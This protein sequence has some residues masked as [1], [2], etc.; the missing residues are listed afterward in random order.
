MRRYVIPP[1]FQSLAVALVINRLD[2]G[3]SIYVGLL[4]SQIRQLQSVQNAASRLVFGLRR[5]EHITDVV[6][7]LHYLRV[8][9]RIA[10][11]VALLIFRAL[12]GQGRRTCRSG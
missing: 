6:V 10:F 12:H 8:Q 9:E 11:K 3:N 2:I 1:V 5:S 4:A 7:C